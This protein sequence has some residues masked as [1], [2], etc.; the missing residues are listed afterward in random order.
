MRIPS[1]VEATRAPMATHGVFLS[2]G[3]SFIV[4]LRHG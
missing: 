4:A 2:R 3:V 1:V